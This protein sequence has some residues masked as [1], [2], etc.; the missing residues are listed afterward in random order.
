MNV[1]VCW[2]LLSSSE[3]LRGILRQFLRE[4]LRV[5]ASCKMWLLSEFDGVDLRQ[6][7]RELLRVVDGMEF[8][9]L[10]MD[11]GRFAAIVTGR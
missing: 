9:E 5:V 8:V 2:F 10:M 4:L 1:C 7:L 11:G 6:F 3:S